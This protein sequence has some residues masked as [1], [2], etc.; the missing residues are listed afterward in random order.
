MQESRITRGRK[1]VAVPGDRGYFQ[2]SNFQEHPASF[3]QDNSIL[4]CKKIEIFPVFCK[5]K[6]KYGNIFN[7]KTGAIGDQNTSRMLDRAVMF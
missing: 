1:I 3:S 5:E 4:D 2:I 6:C 7:F